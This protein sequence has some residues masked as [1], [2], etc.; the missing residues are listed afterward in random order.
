MGDYK[1][2]ISN[3][4]LF[5]YAGVEKHLEKMA[6]KGWQFD[7]IGSFF[8]KYKK[9]EPTKL[10]YSVTYIPESSD[11][12]PEPLEKQKDIEAY[13]EEAGWKKAGN[14]LQMQIFYS[15][16]PDAV[17]IETDEEMRLEYI[18]KSM[19]KNFLTSHLLL[20]F[21]F[22]LD[23]CTQYGLAK[24]N[25]IEYL[26][27]SSWLW[28]CGIRLWGISLLLL[29]I[30]YYL[31]W[32]RKAKRAVVDGLNCPEPRLYRHW[33]RI[34]WLVLLILMIG[35]FGS[36]SS[37]MVW[38]MV[39]YLVCLFLIIILVRKV[40]K[41]LKEEGVSKSGNVVLTIAMCFLLT[42]AVT[43][44]MVAVILG[45]DIGLVEN[46][47]SVDYITV[48]GIEWDVYHDELP[49]YAEDFAKIDFV[50]NSC[51]AEEK[52]S[53]LVSHGDYNQHLFVKEDEVTVAL[54]MRYQMVNVKAKF[55]YDFLLKSFYEREFRYWDEVE[56]EKVEYRMVYETDGATMYR[57]YYDGLPVVHDW[58]V[59]TET[60]IVPMS[61][62]MDDSKELTEE[63]MKI[64]V[65]KLA[66]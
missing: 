17:P 36:Y 59:L 16:S 3:F 25:W 13:C 30:G 26:S 56:K 11:F 60:K 22:I 38:F 64:I 2:Q 10:K 54:A 39:A 53:F 21:V 58:L 35:M 61:I 66:Q 20:L 18:Q 23:A 63:Q 42:F 33:N 27:D 51:Q 28:T 45:F 4:N 50:E 57:Q 62:Y 32:L 29:D 43:G 24:N 34:A 49:L 55:L 48:L 9:A 15:E 5:D 14:W 40:Q 47:K 52:E 37:G 6:A 12:D 46:K 65:D 41:K 44:G 19:K 8:W 7:S 1:Y 31:N